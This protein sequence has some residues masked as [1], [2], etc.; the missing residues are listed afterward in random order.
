MG[1]G[2]DQ[3]RTAV[4]MGATRA[5]H[6][7]CSPVH[8]H[9]ASV[10]MLD[11]QRGLNE[12]VSTSSVNPTKDEGHP[13][14]NGDGPL[15]TFVLEQREAGAASMPTPNSDAHPASRPS[16]QPAPTEPVRLRDCFVDVLAEMAARE[17]ID[18]SPDIEN[19]N[20]IEGD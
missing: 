17:F 6:R 5:V 2:T 20:T 15:P 16:D 14:G 3:R 4:L 12:S 10:H 18:N 11:R 1:I 9:I 19:I 13:R 7:S 8:R